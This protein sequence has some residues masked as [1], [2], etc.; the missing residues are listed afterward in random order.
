MALNIERDH[1]VISSGSM[2]RSVGIERGG[3]IERLGII[4]VSGMDICSGKKGA[5]SLKGMALLTGEE[6]SKVSVEWREA[7]VSKVQWNQMGW[8]HQSR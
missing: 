8:H 5:Y 4:T 7:E 2:G 3:F 6:A 1:D